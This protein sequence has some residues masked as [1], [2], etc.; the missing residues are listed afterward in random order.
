MNTATKTRTKTLSTLEDYL[1]EAESW[2]EAYK[3]R[4]N[5]KVIKRVAKKWAEDAFAY[6]IE[7]FKT[8]NP[9]SFMLCRVE[10]ET[11]ESQVAEYA[12]HRKP[13]TPQKLRSF[14]KGALTGVR[15][16]R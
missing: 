8:L 5:T 7:A 16:Q 2:A 10:G 15:R 9:P 3:D 12:K 1:A 14:L 11:H 4:H 6:G 13:I